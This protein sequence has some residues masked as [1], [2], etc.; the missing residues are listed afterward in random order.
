MACVF[1]FRL[2]IFIAT[3]KEIL[4]FHLAVRIGGTISSKISISYRWCWLIDIK[5]MLK[6]KNTLYQIDD[7][8]LKM[9]S[10]TLW[11]CMWKKVPV[12]SFQTF[13]IA[14]WCS[15]VSYFHILFVLNHINTANLKP[16]WRSR[17]NGGVGGGQAPNLARLTLCFTS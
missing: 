8:V 9:L 15:H 7:K 1:L 4:I 3:E 17:R 10:L 12:Y 14:V 11:G 5:E 13:I 6:Y 2:I 16:H